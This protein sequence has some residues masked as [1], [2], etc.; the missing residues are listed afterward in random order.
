MQRHVQ[1]MLLS[2]EKVAKAESLLGAS[3]TPE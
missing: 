3:G 2:I 1:E